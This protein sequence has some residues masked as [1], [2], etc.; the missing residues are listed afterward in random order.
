M[1]LLI[2]KEAIEK[3]YVNQSEA[4]KILKLTQGRISQLCSDGS[5]EGAVKIGWSWIIPKTTLENYPRQ[6]RGR[7]PKKENDDRTVWANAIKEADNL[8]HRKD[9]NS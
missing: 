5:F 4:A 1:N 6:K 8:K 3:D 7:K 9:D 2:S